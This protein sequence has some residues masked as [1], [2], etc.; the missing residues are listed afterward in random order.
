MP[1]ATFKQGILGGFS[2][3][4]GT[5]I[6]YTLNGQHIMRGIAP[7]VHDANSEKQQ[8]QRARMS[9]VVKTLKPFASAIKSGY[10]NTGSETAWGSAISYHH[11]LAV[12]Q[13]EG[14]NDWVLDYKDI[15]LTNGDELLDIELTAGTD[16]YVT[17]DWETS[18]DNA[19][20]Q[21]GELIVA[22]YN[23]TQ[24]K[25]GVVR[26][27]FNAGTINTCVKKAIGNE[28]DKLHLYYFATATSTVSDTTYVSI[29]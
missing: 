13:T 29:G 4:L 20:Y 14:A 3:K 12:E 28:G 22:L 27:D 7:H 15:N 11:K 23:E 25:G 5:V 19:S 8:S 16:G 17:G 9:A 18:G 2:G 10:I 24:A 21:D 26:I 1:M 6:G